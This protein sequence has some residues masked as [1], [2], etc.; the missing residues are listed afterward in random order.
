MWQDLFYDKY[1]GDHHFNNKITREVDIGDLDDGSYDIHIYEDA[2]KFYNKKF[3]GHFALP[4]CCVHSNMFKLKVYYKKID[5]IDVIY[6]IVSVN[7]EVLEKFVSANDGEIPN[8]QFMRILC[9]FHLSYTSKLGLN[10]YNG[11][12]SKSDKIEESSK[13]IINKAMTAVNYSVDDRVAKIKE[14]TADLFEYQKCSIYWMMQKEKEKPTITYNLNEEVIIGNVYFDFY[15]Q[16]FKTLDNRKSLTFC[17]GGLIDEV[18]LGKTVQ[19]TALSIL[20]PSEST[21]YI[22]KGSNKLHSRA[23]L[24]LC[25]NQLCG[26]WKREFNNMIS[27]KYD[28][29]VVPIMTKRDFDKYTYQDLLDADFVIV[30]YTFL[31][32]KVFTLPWTSK[33]STVKSFH[34]NQWYDNTKKNVSDLFD[35]M[36]EE[37]ISD[38]IETLSNTNPF[39]QLIHWHRVVVDEFHEV[40]CN[41][42]YIYVMNILPF[43]KSTFKWAVTAT[44]FIESNYYSE[45]TLYNTINF[46]TNY[47]NIDGQYILTVQK[48]ID[49]LSEKCFRR[50]TKKSVSEEYKLPPIKEEIRWLKFTATERM[51]YNA[52][53]ANPNNDKFST[54]LRQLCCHPQLAEETKYALSNCKSLQDVE[55]MMVS[56]YKLEVDVSQEKVNKIEERINK[57]NKKIKKIEKKQNKLKKKKQKSKLKKLG[58]GKDKNKGKGKKKIKIVDSDVSDSDDSSDSSNSSDSGDLDIALLLAGLDNDEFDINKITDDLDIGNKP[59]ITLDNLKESL[60]KLESILDEA[61]KELD[62]KKTTFEFFN[63]VIARLRKTVNKDTDK[64]TVDVPVDS[65]TNIMDLLAAEMSDSDD[66]DDSDDS[67][68]EEVCGICLDEIPEDDVGVTKCG[69]IFCYGCLKI[70]TAKYHNCPYCK[71]KLNDNQ[72]Y[73]LS[74]EKKKKESEKT[75]EEKQKDELINEVGTKLA[76]LIFY[77]RETN[78]H[79][80]IFSQWDDL[81]KRVGRILNENGVK[82]VFCKGNCYQRDKAIREFNDDDKVKV[83]MLSSES[84]ASGTNLTKATQVILLDPIYGN[85]KYRKGQERQ[86]IGR[87]HRLGQ[88]NTIKI[89]R[90]IIKDSVEEEIYDLNNAEDAKNQG[91]NTLIN[92]V[93]VN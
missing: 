38:P 60:V 36:G 79:A 54:Y 59:S 55:K 63:N 13:F 42:K 61:N 44:P 22:R 86:A 57:I 24:V 16:K 53:I 45:S 88:K 17:G 67:N 27:K 87:A 52:Y 32:N 18:G 47:E 48:F 75:V 69:H 4:D 21:S 89:V 76:N 11:S 85:Y 25:P 14:I 82:N 10:I 66:N 77:L 28:P 91:M 92:E 71:G 80:I 78:E 20:N 26:Q 7:C 90:L 68:D 9:R 70:S 43:L 84:A 3:K 73:V 39:L 37:L 6:T 62:G 72:I 51:M 46:L 56:H 31:D 74:Y 35:E 40:Y 65:N 30:S 49:Y 50:N 29:I 41:R 19:M 23:T 12:S 15:D 83:I 8:L 64:K 34:R 5:G 1:A 58:I 81:L 93:E 2:L 33:L